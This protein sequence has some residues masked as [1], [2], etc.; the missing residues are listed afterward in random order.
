MDWTSSWY[1]M[2]RT[3]TPTSNERDTYPAP[4]PQFT[5][6]LNWFSTSVTVLTPFCIPPFPLFPM[7]LICIL[8]IYVAPDWAAQTFQ[9]KSHPS[10][11]LPYWGGE[12]SGDTISHHAKYNIYICYN[13]KMYSLG[14]VLV[15]LSASGS[16]APA[17]D[18]D[19]WF[20]FI[21]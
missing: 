1:S 3:H 18:S 7:H 10:T 15:A 9:M 4:P 8:C 13:I 21:K 5:L 2:P 6:P 16:E 19:W 12:G 14:C 17:T 11:W 20:S